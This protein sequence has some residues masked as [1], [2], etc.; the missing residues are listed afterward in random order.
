MKLVLMINIIDFIEELEKSQDVF[1]IRPKNPV[2]IGRT[3]K[4]KE[5]FFKLYIHWKL[6]KK[7]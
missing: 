3:E 1:V 7:T 5:K 2:K 6:D 4:N